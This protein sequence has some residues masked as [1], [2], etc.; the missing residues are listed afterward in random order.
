M[1]FYGYLLIC[2]IDY[3][4]SNDKF[5]SITNNMTRFRGLETSL[6]P[7]KYGGTT[8]TNNMTRFRGLE[9][10]KLDFPLLSVL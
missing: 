4:D 8:I 2:I 5:A 10:K 1:W 6:A 7:H 3:I 9:I